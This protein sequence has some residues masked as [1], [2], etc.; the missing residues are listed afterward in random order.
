TPSR[1]QAI[2]ACGI[3]PATLSSDTKCLA[4][5]IQSGREAARGTG[6]P[7]EQGMCHPLQHENARS[8]QRQRDRNKPTTTTVRPAC[9][10]SAPA[11]DAVCPAG[12]V[13]AVGMTI[14]PTVNG[15]GSAVEW[16]VK[17]TKA[18]GTSNFCHRACS[19]GWHLNFAAVVL[20]LP[21]AIEIAGP[22]L[23]SPGPACQ[24]SDGQPSSGGFCFAPENLFSGKGRQ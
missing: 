8:H 16:C 23:N 21:S 1:D 13:P 17:K 4:K 3:L 12:K 10:L 2:A 18:A 24:P 22:K 9:R 7:G 14:K 11:G 20:P 19:A 6:Q 15:M 5:R